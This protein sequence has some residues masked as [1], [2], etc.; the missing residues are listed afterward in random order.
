METASLEARTILETRH[1]R[2]LR[3]TWQGKV[4]G[5]AGGQLGAAVLSILAHN[6]ER[7]IP[8]LLAVV[9]PGYSGVRAPFYCSAARVLESGQVAADLVTKHGQLVKRAEVFKS[10]GAMQGALR[11]LADAVKLDDAERVEFFEAAR[12]WVVADHRLDPTMDRKDP[13][14]KR[15][16]Q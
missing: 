14:A 4:L 3:D 6:Y 1:A 16:L 10:E 8:V 5:H 13:D 12:R 7:A 11:R 15:F 9:F 2:D